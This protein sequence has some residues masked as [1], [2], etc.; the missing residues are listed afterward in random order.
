MSTNTQKRILMVSPV[1][2]LRTYSGFQ[3]LARS[4]VTQGFQVSVLASIPPAMLDEA[5]TIFPDS[6]HSFRSSLLGSLP[7]V[8]KWE[9]RRQLK[10]HL[11]EK[12]D[13]VVLNC[14]NP[15]A[16]L[17]EFAEYRKSVADSRLILY[18]PELWLPGEITRL[19]TSMLDGYMHKIIKADFVI[20]VEEERAR[21]RKQAFALECDVEVIPNTLPASLLPKCT[22]RGTL[23]KVL[24]VPIDTHRKILFY[25][26][27]ATE[28]SI[29]ELCSIM[30]GVSANVILVWMSHGD[31]HVARKTQQQIDKRLG[32]GRCV[33]SRSIPR[34]RLLEITHE[35]DAGLIV[36]PCRERASANQRNAAPTKLYEFLASGLPILSYGNPSIRKLIDRF[37]VGSYALED[38]P[39]SLA[40][41]INGLM[42]RSDLEDI[43]R[44]ASCAFRD[45]LCY[46]K[47]G[48]AVVEHLSQSIRL[49][50][51]HGA[52]VE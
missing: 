1:N 7:H 15:T 22:G 41:A 42:Q 20:D 25:T 24:G 28:Q 16:L 45:Y 33:V 43:S 14:I 2:F 37:K 38:S 11:Q 23:Q 40:A 31:E 36:Y 46:E 9:Y 6:F 35:A 39:E 21:L 29:G 3:Y 52:D 44:R 32:V 47:V 34:K 5:K 12:P 13:A 26:G 10:K 48:E 49:A 27:Q 30:K 17:D 18:C 19:S 50:K 4:L 8:W 51:T